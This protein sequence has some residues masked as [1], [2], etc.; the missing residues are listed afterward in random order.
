[1]TSPTGV[2]NR[3]LPHLRQLALANFFVATKSCRRFTLA[4]P[5]GSGKLA[6]ARLVSELLGGDTRMKAMVGHAR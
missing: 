3:G 4:S 6:L 2:E 1:M 5:S